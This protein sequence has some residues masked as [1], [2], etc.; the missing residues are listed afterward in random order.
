MYKLSVP[1]SFNSVTDKTM[2]VFLENFRK[3]KVD[4]VFLSM[5][6]P[7]YDPDNFICANEEKAERAI[8]Y[9]KD[10]G[11]EVGVWIGG[12]GHGGVLSH[13]KNS[14]DK[15]RFVP[16]EGVYGDKFGYAYCPLDENFA[17]HYSEIVRKVAAMHPDLIMLDDDYRLNLRQYYMGCFC[18]LHRKEYFRRIGE[19]IPRKKLES[20]IFTGGKNKYRSAYLKL[21]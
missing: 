14:L 12:F 11:L 4:R 3:C 6:E 19:E 9:F 21:S 13:E 20:L 10:N 7:V 5:L 15:D 17:K 2:P 8:R 1:V 18:P 16:M